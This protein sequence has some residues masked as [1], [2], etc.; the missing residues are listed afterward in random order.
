MRNTRRKM[1][2]AARITSARP[3]VKIGMVNRKIMASRPP[4]MKPMAKE[5]ISISGPRIATRMIIM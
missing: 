4:M 3:M 2:V 1:G 5:K